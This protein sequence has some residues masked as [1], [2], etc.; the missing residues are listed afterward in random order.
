M[1][2]EICGNE[3]Q[4]KGRYKKRTCS[5]SCSHSLQRKTMGCSPNT[6]HGYTG[7][8]LHNVWRSIIDR[9]KSHK[10]YA[11]RG[12]EICEEWLDYVTF[13]KWSIDNGYSEDL[14]IDRIDND[15]NYTPSNCRWTTM[16]VQCRNRRTSRTMIH[17]GET[18]TFAE[19]AEV[20]S[21]PIHTLYARIDKLGWAFDKAIT[22]PVRHMVRNK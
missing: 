9:C 2:C 7:E 13:R 8:K 14:T 5:K 21:I 20:S 3:Y 16:K 22:T 11:S 18:K 6:K 4:I 17:N 15:G 12:I 19:W 1:V 10:D